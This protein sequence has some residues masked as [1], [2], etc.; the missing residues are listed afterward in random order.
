MCGQCVGQCVS[1]HVNDKCILGCKG[2]RR[3]LFET[4][5]EVGGAHVSAA[6]RALDVLLEEPPVGLQHLRRLLVQG[7]LGVGLLREGHMGAA[8]TDQIP[9]DLSLLRQ[10]EH[11]SGI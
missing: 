5:L 1:A 11:S 8:S 3:G 2:R 10:C 9:D 6:Q 4:A 7:V